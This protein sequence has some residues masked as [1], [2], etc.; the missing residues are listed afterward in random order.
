[1]EHL[2]KET[3]IEK[4]FDYEHNKEWDFKG[5]KPCIIDFYADWCAPCR[6]VSPILEQIS[7]D[8]E[9]LVDVYKIDT[10]KQQELASIFGVK[11]IPSIL[12]VPVGDTPRMSVGALP[13]ESFEKAIDD[14][15]KVQKPNMN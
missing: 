2:S 13:K 10:E 12:F 6:M 3:F 5:S 1:M 11:S 14:I 9:G 7:K 8:Y 4:I 15:F